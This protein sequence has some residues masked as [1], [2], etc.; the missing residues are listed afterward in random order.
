MSAP[1]PAEHLVLGTSGPVVVVSGRVSAWLLSRAGLDQYHRE[2]RGDDPEVDQL[3]VALKIAAHIWRE[4]NVSADHGTVAVDT[5][6]KPALSP[7]WLTTTAAARTLG[8]GP[9]AIRKAIGAGR[10]RATWAGG[11]WWIDP[12]DVAHYRAQRQA[13]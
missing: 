8:I 12:E 6:A 5:P 10:L 11:Q 2:H 9:R 4:G 3:L 13:A 1:R 7:Q